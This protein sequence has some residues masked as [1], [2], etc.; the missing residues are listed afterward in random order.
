MNYYIELKRIRSEL[1]DRKDLLA[2]ELEQLPDGVLYCYTSHGIDCYSQRVPVG[3]NTKKE[4]RIGI[5]KDKDLL[6]KLVR[7][8]YVTQAIGVLE[9]DLKAFDSLIRKYRPSDENSVM[10]RFLEKHPELN[11][12]I[13]YDTMSYQERVSQFHSTG[14]FHQENLKSTSADGSKRRSL[15][16]IIIGSRLTHYGIPH[17]YEASLDHPDIPYVPDFTIIRPRDGKIIYWEHLGKVNDRAYMEWNRQKFDVYERYGIVP[18]ENLIVSYSQ[19]DSGI[20]EKL[21]NALIQGWLL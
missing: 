20:N 4:H 17:K 18:W 7:K 5:A 19:E 14:D 2:Q 9:K 13:Y 6:Y 10:Q 21:I 15:G 8:E 12:G 1:Q 3:G 11:E 16:E